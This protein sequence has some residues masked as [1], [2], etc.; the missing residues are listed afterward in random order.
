M[1]C[2]AAFTFTN[3]KHHCRN[4][5]HVFDHQC[6][7]KTL[8][9]PHF[10]IKQA[11][12]VD[13]GCYIKLTQ[14]ITKGYPFIDERSP[15]QWSPHQQR[16]ANLMQPRSA[17]V[18]DVFDE[19]FKK[20]LAMSLEEVKGYSGISSDQKASQNSAYPK[21]NESTHKLPLRSTEEEDK[22]L[23]SA[24]AASLADMEEQKKKNIV[25]INE[26][27]ETPGSHNSNNLKPPKNDHTITLVEVENINLF[28]NLVDRLQ[29]QP[30]GAVLREPKIQELYDNIAKLRP[31]ITRTYGEIISKHGKV[32]N[33]GIIISRLII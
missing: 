18:D 30:P 2:R 20:A 19:D 23:E 22:D 29:T 33:T 4:C 6:S 21:F 8:P 26:Q 9:L 16:S 28:S 5:G 31:K 13:D 27:V 25:K 32:Y 7:S 14:K 24:I 17:R 11:V 1:R 10:G 3:R 12:R 15:N